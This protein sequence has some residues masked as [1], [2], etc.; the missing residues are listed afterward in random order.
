MPERFT[1]LLVH[2]HPDDES[3]STGGVMARYAAEGARVVC[4]TC[5]GGEHG[6]I[7]VPELDTPE[8]HARLAGLR[9]EEIGRALERLGPIEHRWL[10]YVDSGM[11]GTP[12]NDAPDSFWQADFAVATERLLAIVAEVRPQVM[13]S[14]NDYGGYGHPDHIR[15]ALVTKAA[16]ERAAHLPEAPLKLYEV[17][18]DWTRMDEVRRR[19][20]ERGAQAWWQPSPDETDEQ[21]RER[22]QQMAAMA[23]AQGPI[24]TRVDVGDH[25]AAKHAAMAEHVSQLAPTFPFLA[26]TPEDWRELMPTEDFTL[27]ISR[28]GVRIPEDDLFAGLR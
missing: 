2:A 5:T 6:E 28:V 13:V 17:T 7:V 9:R 26:L 19:A 21:R 11:M 14:Y 12:E 3:I 23:A 1:L 27:R 22:E 18:R 4:V 10:G 8:N 15:A 20:E 16:F 24:T 25:V